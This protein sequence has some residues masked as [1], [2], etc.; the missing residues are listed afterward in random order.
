MPSG[1][2]R[3]GGGRTGPPP[4]LGRSVARSRRAPASLRRAT[5]ARAQEATTAS[6]PSLAPRAPL[7]RLPRLT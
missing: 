3:G 1:D 7:S 2:R 6:S 4:P 5:L